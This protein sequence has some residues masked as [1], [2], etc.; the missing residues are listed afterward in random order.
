MGNKFWHQ[1]VNCLCDF[2][3]LL[4]ATAAGMTYFHTE[5][6]ACLKMFSHEWIGVVE[7]VVWFLHSPD[8]ML[9]DFCLRIREL[10]SVHA[11]DACFAQVAALHHRG[12]KTRWIEMC[13]CEYGRRQSF[14]LSAE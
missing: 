3:R 13:G 5:V 6:R 11:F 4:D 12:M 9:L 8:L 14:G 7:S 10:S 2:G 1:T